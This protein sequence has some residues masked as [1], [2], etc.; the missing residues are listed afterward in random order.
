MKEAN[1]RLGDFGYKVVR[2]DTITNKRGIWFVSTVWIGMSA[3]DHL[4]ETMIFDESGPKRK[5]TDFQRR[6]MTEMNAFAGH[7]AAVLALRACE[8]G[9]P[10]DID[11][12]AFDAFKAHVEE[13]YDKF[14]YGDG[15]KAYIAALEKGGNGE[16]GLGQGVAPDGAEGGPTAPKT[17]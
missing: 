4:F 6:Y 3:F 10:D 1:D 8:S 9:N 7:Y 5:T 15:F 17:G 13:N 2:Q 11:D 14:V 16:S 12:A